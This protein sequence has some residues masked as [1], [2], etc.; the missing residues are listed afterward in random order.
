MSF[1]SRLFGSKSTSSPTDVEAQL[2]QLELEAEKALPGYVGTSFN[3]AGDLALRDGQTDRAMGYYGRSIDAFLEDAQREA[4]RGVANKI[5]R[6]RPTAVRTLCTLTWLDLAARHHATALLHLRDYAAAAGEAGEQA[7]AA[8][9]IHAMARMS[10]DAEFIGAVADALDGLGYVNRADE[11]RGWV[12]SGAPDAPADAH[13]LGAA[14]LEA[15]VRSNDP[16]TVLLSDDF[17]PEAPGAGADEAEDDRAAG[18]PVAEAGGPGD[19]DAEVQ[20]SAHSSDAVDE[21][22][23]S[24]STAQQGG[25]RKGRK[26]REKKKR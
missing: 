14:C 2:R 7:R 13:E 10:D 22:A 1:L 5:I 26:N 4:A 3:R 20:D 12:T 23:S 6:V 15:A 19:A 24:D 11:V 9:Q 8:T 25:D 18:G 16:D 21:D 17:E